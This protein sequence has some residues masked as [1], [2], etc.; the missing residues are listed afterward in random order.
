MKT[1]L[2]ILTLS[3]IVTG[4]GSKRSNSSSA[5]GRNTTT[6]PQV[7]E[8]A[9]DVGSLWGSVV[10]TLTPA[11]YSNDSNLQVLFQKA[12]AGLMQATLDPKYIG[13]V[14][15]NPSDLSTAT[16]G[17]RFYGSVKISQNA[18]QK[19]GA[20]LRISI[21]DSYAGNKDDKGNTIPEYPLYFTQMRDPIIDNST[22]SVP[23]V[24]LVFENE[25]TVVTLDGFRS[26]S[27][28]VGN[29]AYENKVNFDGGAT[30]KSR[31][32]FGQFSVP[33]CGFFKGDSNCPNK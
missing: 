11:Q 15:G 5:V 31:P 23:K 29:I 20:L 13:T 28:F 6:Q 7:S 1:L 17:V 2:L 16:T 19:A 30:W 27:N 22:P 10:A 26:G 3:V 33:Y 25:F 24:R 32:Y 18:A 12:V 21:W 9:A 4:C 8:T 14:S